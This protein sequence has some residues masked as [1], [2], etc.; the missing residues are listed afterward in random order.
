METRAE[1]SPSSTTLCPSTGSSDLPTTPFPGA[2]PSPVPCPH[3]HHVVL[4]LLQPHAAVVT[5][6]AG[7]GQ[8]VVG[9]VE[10][11]RGGTTVI[12]FEGLVG[13]VATGRQESVGPTAP[14][15]PT[16]P[17]PPLHSTHHRAGLGCLCSGDRHPS[18]C[19]DT[20]PCA[21]TP[22][23]VQGHPSRFRDTLGE[24]DSQGAAAAVVGVVAVRPIR[25]AALAWGG[26]T[27]VSEWGQASAVAPTPHP[28]ARCHPARCP[29]A[30]HSCWRARAGWALRCSGTRRDPHTRCSGRRR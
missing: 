17:P 20:H 29:H 30:T 21:G 8:A 15:L 4:Q 26:R 3:R 23:P 25:A 16:C 18:L 12:C 14:R 1:H 7:G 28:S 10:G 19:R 5:A 22:M 24:A 13:A 2:G 6:A 27:E 9:L 11:G